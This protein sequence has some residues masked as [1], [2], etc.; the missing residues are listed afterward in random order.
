MRFSF[1]DEQEE[2]R[3]VLRRFLAREPGES[4]LDPS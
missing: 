2:F 4:V 1:S 3:L